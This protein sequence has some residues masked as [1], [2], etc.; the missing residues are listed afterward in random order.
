MQVPLT[1][2]YFLKNNNK[3][4]NK[5]T[6]KTCRHKFCVSKHG[7]KSWWGT[8]KYPLPLLNIHS[9]KCKI[10]VVPRLSL[11]H[12]LNGFVIFCLLP[13]SVVSFS[14]HFQRLFAFQEMVLNCAWTRGSTLSAQLYLSLSPSCRCS[15]RSYFSSACLKDTLRSTTWASLMR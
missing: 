4:N 6:P 7:K 10:R 12:F 13:D 9:H 1:P 14:Q 8:V 11:L 5:T 2:M 15:L 3:N